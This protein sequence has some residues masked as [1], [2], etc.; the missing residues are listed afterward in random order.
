MYGREIF[1]SAPDDVCVMHLTAKGKHRMNLEVT[2]SRHHIY[3][4]S[5]KASGDSIV[6]GGNLGRDGLDYAMMCRAASPDGRIEVIG[7]SITVYD[8]TEVFL[9]WSALTTYRVHVDCAD[10]QDEGLVK[11]DALRDA[12]ARKLDKAAAT[13]YGLSLI[14]I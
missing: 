2:Q 13:D 1:M 11:K 6:L 3:E 12:L 5:E 14:H 4:Y 10:G 8:A 7:E 9:Y